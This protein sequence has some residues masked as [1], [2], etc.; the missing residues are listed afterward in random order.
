M[1]ASASCLRSLV[2]RPDIDSGGGL[3][4]GTRLVVYRRGYRHHGIYSGTGRVIHYAG[5]GN[6]PRGCIEEISLNHFMGNRPIDVG[7]APDPLR[8]RDILRRARSRLG[9]CRYDLLTNN[10]EHF[11]NW[12]ELGESRSQQVESLARP[13]RLLVRAAAT[14]ATSVPLSMWLRAISTEAQSGVVG[15]LA[16]L[17]YATGV[18]RAAQRTAAEC[19]FRCAT[20]PA[21]S[22]REG[23]FPAEDKSMS[24]APWVGAAILL[25]GCVVSHPPPKQYDF[26]NFTALRPATSALAVKLVTRDVTE[27]SWLR[28][29]DIFYRLDYA[30]PSSP[31]RYAMSQWVAT[32]G[33]LVT[34]R[35]RDAVASANAGYTLTASN[36]SGGY[37]LQATLEEFTQVFTEPAKSDC[38]VQLRV[39]LWKSADQITAERVFRIEKTAQ[40]P[41]ASG[42]ATCLASA[43][44]MDVNEIVQWLSG[45]VSGTHSSDAMALTQT[46]DL[47]P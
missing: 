36:G 22:R 3:V 44:N 29:R 18:A 6:Y 30:A 25:V 32:P 42:G 13:V 21:G 17:G 7:T 43:V 28:T 38:I 14:L 31:R 4:A 2:E 11:C 26:G 27:P 37:S 15:S 8:A 24:R 12:C 16:K 23:L 40:A 34:L 39:S 10:C 19:A 45:A 5:R 47:R 20:R 1:N 35:L 41:D 9:E 46:P 33:E